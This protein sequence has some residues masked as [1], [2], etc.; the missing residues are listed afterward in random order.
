MSVS[1]NISTPKHSNGGCKDTG[2]S[3]LI[4]ALASH[5]AQQQQHLTMLIIKFECR[6]QMQSER[7]TRVKKQLA[8]VWFPHLNIINGSVG[9]PWEYAN[10]NCPIWAQG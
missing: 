2:A 10:D 7:D 3:R 9:G 6:M 5:I 8:F 1:N 4:H